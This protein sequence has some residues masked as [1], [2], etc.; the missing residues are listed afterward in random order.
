MLL[1]TTTTNCLPA[2]VPRRAGQWNQQFET[3]QNQYDQ[4]FRYKLA[5]ELARYGDFSGFE[6]LGVDTTQMKAAWEA[7]QR[8]A[9]LQAQGRG[10]SRSAGAAGGEP[11]PEENAAQGSGGV[12]EVN[13]KGLKQTVYT[14][15]NLGKPEAALDA[16]NRTWNTLT[17]SQRSELTAYFA[18]LGYVLGGG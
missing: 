17:P 2:A 5:Q 6:A 18:N 10:N 3:G 9:M 16:A 7:Q 12:S 13:F 15:I 14:Y 8:L 4:S 11:W 1:S